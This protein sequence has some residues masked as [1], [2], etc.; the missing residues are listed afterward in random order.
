MV[1]IF[2]VIFSFFLVSS[3]PLFASRVE[4]VKDEE[5]FWRLLVDNNP[6]F[7]KGITYE[8]VKVGERITSANE[9]MNYDFNHNGI[10]DTAYETW[11]DKNRN[12]KQDEDE[13]PVG[14]FYLMKEMGVNTIRIYPPTN[15]KKDI[16]RD[17]YNR[18]GIRVIMGN[19][20]G[21]YCWGSG[22]DWESGTDYTDPVHLKNMLE[23]VKR[24]VLE[25]K[26]EPYILAWLLG[27]ENDA[28]GSYENSTFN[29]TNGTP[30]SR[31]VC[32]IRG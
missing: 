17:L 2:T 4:L 18:F 11:I 24:M 25:F 21:A 6:Y 27:N 14:D 13:E 1:K 23:D 5:G 22:A 31:S 29:N 30:L 16:L 15:I 7:I 10:N 20:L 3:E 12:N 8:P 9:W 32:Q 19:Y 28:E 26:D